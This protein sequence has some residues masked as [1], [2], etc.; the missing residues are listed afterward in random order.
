[1]TQNA[2]GT[3]DQVL[4]FRGNGVNIGRANENAKWI[5]LLRHAPGASSGL[6]E[7]HLAAP[8]RHD[9]VVGVTARAS[10]P[11]SFP[12]GDRSG[13]VVARNDGESTDSGISDIRLLPRR[14][15]AV[16]DFDCPSIKLRHAIRRLSRMVWPCP[17]QNTAPCAKQLGW[18]L[19]DCLKPITKFQTDPLPEGPGGT[20]HS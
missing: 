8:T 7:V 9:D 5:V 19:A 6:G 16:V 2:A 3:N 15:A 17:W 1:M 10:K 18:R 13:Q 12:K 11:E 14:A 20:A 4:Y